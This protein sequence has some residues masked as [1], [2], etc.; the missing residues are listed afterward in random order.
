LCRNVGARCYLTGSGGSQSYLDSE[1]LGRAGVGVIWQTFEHPVY[2]Q[3][4]ERGFDSHLGFID[5]VLNHGPASREL[6]MPSSH[7]ARLA[8]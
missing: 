5:L 7:P 6:L 2:A 4:Y 3:R 1:K 8:A